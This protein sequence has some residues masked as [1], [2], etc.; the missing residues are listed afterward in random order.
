MVR[1][2]LAVVAALAVALAEWP[3]WPEASAAGLV[4]AFGFEEDAG[5][6]AADASGNANTAQLVGAVWTTAG[7]F[8]NALVFNGTDAR[9]TLIDDAPELRLTTAMTLE[10]WVKPSVVTGVWR[11]VIY[12]GNDNYFLEATTDHSAFP[13]GGGIFGGANTSAFGTAALAAGA[14]THLAT[15]YDGTRLRLYINGT[16]AS[17]VS[18]T[19]AI[20]TSTIPLQIGGDSYFGQSFAGTIDEVRVYNRA[21]TLSEIQSDMNTPVA[22]AVVDGFAPSK[23]EGLTATAFTGTQVNLSWTASTDDVGVTEYRVERCRGAGCASFALIGAAPGAQHNDT[24]L[25]LNTGYTYRVRAADAA[26]NLSPVSEIASATTHSTTSAPGL[27]AAYAFDE[28]SGTAVT[29]SSGS[30]NHGVIT[31]A[32]WTIAGR[33]GNALAFNGTN[34]RVTINDAASLH[35]TTGMTLEAWVLPLALPAKNCSTPSCSWMDVIHKE[36]DS[37]YIEASSDLNQ[38][39]EAGGI[40]VAGK[41]IVFGPAPLATNAWTHLALT[42]DAAMVRFFV[43]GTL[44]AAG[45]ETTS[46]TTS[47]GPLRIG[48]DSIFGQ[49]FKGTIDEVRVY[50]RALTG[51]EIGGD[52]SAPIGSGSANPT[53]AIA[54]LVPETV[55]AG[56]ADFTLTVQGSGF[57]SGSSVQWNGADRPTT[58]VGPTELHAAIPATDVAAGGTAAVTVFNAPPIGGTSPAAPFAICAALPE[59]CNGVDDDCDA[60]ID[61]ADPSLTNAIA[62]YRD[63]DG[64]EHG[65]PASA[66][67][68]CA[69]PV[70]YVSDAG[71]CDDTAGAVWSVPGEVRSVTFV[72]TAAMVWSTPVAWGGSSLRYDALRADAPTAFDLA[73]CVASGTTDATAADTALPVEGAGFYYLLRATNSC[74]GG[75]LGAA[76]DGALRFGPACP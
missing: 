71:D 44:V 53:P 68:A 10:A 62:W 66:Q 45:Q 1:N 18:R 30:G 35:L 50:S 40:F 37:Y 52:M 56:G 29:D 72:D 31:N 6:T 15:T 17:S 16:E 33:Y 69:Q 14:W 24:G 41:H 67:A 27:V 64:D 23:P 61:D 48:G 5:T 7:K 70:G 65:D 21:L 54:G 75:T 25:A 51:A 20:R 46:L 58:I 47:T 49:Y 42:Y 57:Y 39:P 55:V 43:N 38:Q 12:K 63:A 76:S 26:G 11:D 74:G 19:G 59:I 34:A 8:G 36:P 60:L 13:A 22:A 2:H 73:A 28:G 9:V 4:A 32:T 3:A